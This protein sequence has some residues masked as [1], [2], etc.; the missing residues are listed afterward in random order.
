[1]PA[2]DVGQPCTEG[3][4]CQAGHCECDKPNTPNG[5]HMTGACPEFALKKEDGAICVVTNGIARAEGM[6]VE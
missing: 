2:V 4:H 6:R 3:A 5:T 1:M